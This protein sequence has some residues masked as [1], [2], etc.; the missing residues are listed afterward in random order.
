VNLRS[1]QPPPRLDDNN[2]DENHMG[3]PHPGGSPVLKTDGSVHNYAYGYVGQNSPGIADDDAFW[4]AM[5]AWNRSFVVAY[6]D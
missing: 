3:G 2:V 6:S 5:W 1:K 4:Q